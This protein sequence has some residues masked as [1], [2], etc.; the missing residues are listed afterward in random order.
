[1]FIDKEMDKDV[2][3]DSGWLPGHKK[4]WNKAICSNA[5]ATEDKS[6]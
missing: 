6:Y 4:E 5:D 3:G 2:L 1:M